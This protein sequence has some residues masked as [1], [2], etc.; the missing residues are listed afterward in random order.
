MVIQTQGRIH[1][2]AFAFLRTN[3]GDPKPRKHGVTEISG[4]Y[5]TPLGK[6]YLKDI[7]VNLFV[8][9]SQIVQLECLRS[10]I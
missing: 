1:E 6:R 2:K 8:N 5:Y 3:E 10:R 4:P 9:H 7:L